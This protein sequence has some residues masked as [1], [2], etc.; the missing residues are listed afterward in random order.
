MVTNAATADA[1]PKLVYLDLNHWIA[2]AMAPDH[3]RGE[4]M[5]PEAR[6]EAGCRLLGLSRALERTDSIKE[7]IE[8]AVRSE[9]VPDTGH[10]IVATVR[11]LEHV[12]TER[13]ARG[14]RSTDQGA[15]PIQRPRLLVARSPIC[16]QT[17]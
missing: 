14:L 2:L 5:L 6:S 4:G 8:D 10:E 11:G 1:P 9:L 17:R 16:S 12:P 15:L 13:E 3:E 7:L